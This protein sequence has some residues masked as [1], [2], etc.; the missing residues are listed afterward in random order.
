LPLVF[1]YL[2]AGVFGRLSMLL[3]VNV[4]DCVGLTLISNISLKK[5]RGKL[6][7]R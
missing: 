3:K 7:D 6:I 5:S 1:F 4:D 2:L